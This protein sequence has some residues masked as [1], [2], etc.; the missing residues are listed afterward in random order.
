MKKLL[1]VLLLIVGIAVVAA[2]SLFLLFDPNDFR[3]D[4]SAEVERVTGREF[5]IEGEIELSYFPWLAI[6][7]GHT[8]LGNAQGF[9]D[10]PFASFERARLSVQLLPMLL[11]RKISVGTA[12]LD[13]LHLN[14][15]V[16]RNG[17]GNWEDL[18]HASEAMAEE[19]GDGEAAPGSIDIAS[20]SVSNATVNYSDAQTGESYELTNLNLS[21]GRIAGGDPVPLSASFDF[22]LQPSGTAGD[23]A[24][25]AVIAADLHANTVGLSDVEISA[26][27][28]DI[29]ADVE[30]FSYEGDLLPVATLNVATFA[31]RELMQ[32]FGIEAPETADP[33]VLGEM[34]L[35]AVARVSPS[36]VALED[37]DIVLDDTSF[38]GKLSIARGTSGTISVELAGDSMDLGRYMAPAD[39]SE[40]TGAESAPTEVPADL[41]RALNMRG[42][43]ALEEVLLGGM[44]FSAV[45]FGLNVSNDRLRLHPANATLYGGTYAGDVRIDAS[46]DVP[47]MSLDERLTGIDIG[48]L[49]AAVFETDNIS[50]TFNGGFN[51]TGR[52][53][54]LDTIERSLGGSM[55]LEILDGV[56]GGTDVWYELR[57]A[58]ALLKKEAVPAREEPVQTEFSQ[59]RMTGPVK[60]GVFHND[61]VFAELDF[62]QV[63]GSGT[64]DLP[65]TDIDYKLT[66]RVIDKPEFEDG[67]T[68]EEQEEFKE[69]IIPLRVTGTAMEPSIKPDIEAMLKKE[70]KKKAREKLLEKL[71]GDDEAGAEDEPAKQEDDK[72][73]LKDALRDLLGR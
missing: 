18:V 61:D 40:G 48:S 57:R 21:T 68:A 25:D 3:D 52:G 35:D 22:E 70:V 13:A 17:R 41:I 66:A 45:S 60:D 31:P 27:G 8:R 10:E 38:T 65:S 12:S 49:M 2:I 54:D 59:V 15:A 14:L 37:L 62:M 28:V 51:L 67:A 33:D 36:A 23:F 50:G 43:L 5:A 39:E 1:L 47:V 53:A 26:M 58:R 19:G 56:Y 4:I 55:R 71:L 42:R 63:T 7:I 32:Y 64:V 73:R 30:P 44:T 11:S 69:A 46:G 24:I 16:D 34:R 20:I 6:D 9:G 72:D 29:S